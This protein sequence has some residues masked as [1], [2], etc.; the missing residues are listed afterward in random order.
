MR[1]RRSPSPPAGP[2]EQSCHPLAVPSAPVSPWALA[3]LAQRPLPTAARGEDAPKQ[4][5]SQPR[6]FRGTLHQGASRR[7]AWRLPQTPGNGDDAAAW[8]P[9][10]VG[11]PPCGILG[12]HTG[13]STGG[14]PPGPTASVPPPGPA[15]GIPEPVPGPRLG[16]PGAAPEP[17]G[18]CRAPAPRPGAGLQEPAKVLFSFSGRSE[19]VW[20]IQFYP[21]GIRDRQ[22]CLKLKALFNSHWDQSTQ[23][24]RILKPANHI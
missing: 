10:P 1:S 17:G 19:Q 8:Y 24:R 2:R 23:R 12:T 16:P 21:L 5:P 15:V 4:S 18:T 13:R 7:G 22:S 9:C 3:S 6:C 11:P 14:D 20:R